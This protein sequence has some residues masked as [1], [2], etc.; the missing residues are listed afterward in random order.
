MSQSI[1]SK[2][3][4]DSCLEICPDSFKLNIYLADLYFKKGNIEKIVL[5]HNRIINFPETDDYFYFFNVGKSYFYL[6]KYSDAVIAYQKA[7]KVKP[8]NHAIHYYIAL[9]FIEIGDSKMTLKHL[10]SLLVKMPEAR[11]SVLETHAFKEI[12]QTDTFKK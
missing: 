8:G 4:P 11:K 6:E 1:P 12:V 2:Y 7:L 9:C 5:Y 3:P 10:K